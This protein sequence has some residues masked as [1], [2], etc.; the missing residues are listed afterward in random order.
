MATATYMWVT[1]NL[2]GYSRTS[3][4]VHDETYPEDIDKTKNTLYIIE[5]AVS[6][7]VIVTA[8]L[9]VCGHKRTLAHSFAGHAAN[10]TL[11]SATWSP[12][13]AQRGSAREAQPAAR[14]PLSYC[15]NKD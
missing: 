7:V 6:Q 10:A 9:C 14:V 15:A 2:H 11:L 3:V 4:N 5:H 13:S 8:N 1:N 12:A